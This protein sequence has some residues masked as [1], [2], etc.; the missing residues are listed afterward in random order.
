MKIWREKAGV[1]SEEP[2]WVALHGC[3][4]Y[5]ADTLLGLLWLAVT[6]WNN[7]RHLAG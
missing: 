6:E 3:Y 2:C 4:L 5:T 7:D 1:L